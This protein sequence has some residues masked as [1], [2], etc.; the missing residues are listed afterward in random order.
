M[1]DIGIPLSGNEVRLRDI[2]TGLSSNLQYK[3]MT[4]ESRSMKI[5]LK[6]TADDRCSDY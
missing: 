6:L 2:G 5:S 3:T 4:K 1:D